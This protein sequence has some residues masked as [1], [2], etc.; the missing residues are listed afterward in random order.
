MVAPENRRDPRRSVQRRKVTVPDLL[1]LKEQGIR[2]TAL[3]AYD[4]PFGALVDAAG[5]DMVLVGDTASSVVHGNETT[6]SMTLEEMTVLLKAVRRGVRYGLL[7]ADL[8]FGYC[9]GGSSTSQTVQAAVSLV[10]AG[11]EAVK[12][13]GG[14]KRV[15]LVRELVDAEVPVVAHIGLTPQAVHTMGGYRV[16]GKTARTAD[17]LVADAQALESAGAFA[18]VLEGIPQEVASHITKRL[19][20][21]TIGI[22][23]GL[24]CDGQILVL[25]DMLGLTVPP[26]PGG[27]EHIAGKKPR[28]VREYLDLRN[29]VRE[30]IERYCADV[31]SDEFPGPAETYRLSEA[32][33]RSLRS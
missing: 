7:V 14:A 27:P 22:G 19:R 21:P 13:E 15:N 9:H 6:L 33:T 2:I 3:T 10:K 23:A 31:R 16:Q 24:G 17:I 29:V 25:H 4:Y 11:A 12:L 18:V 30:A 20:I 5:V 26:P 8:P 28:F 1:A 32:E